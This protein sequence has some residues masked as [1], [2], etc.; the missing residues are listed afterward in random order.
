MPKVALS[1]TVF[2]EL[3]DGRLHLTTETDG[4]VT[5]T[6][7]LDWDACAALLRYLTTLPPP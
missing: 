7:V 2:V 1:D 6:I 3:V 4:R 5:N